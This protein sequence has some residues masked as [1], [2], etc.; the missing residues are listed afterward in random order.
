MFTFSSKHRKLKSKLGIYLG[1]KILKDS[2][3]LRSCCETCHTI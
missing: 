3:Y 2:S 1:K